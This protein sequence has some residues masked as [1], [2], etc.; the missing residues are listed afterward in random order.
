M[1]N[2]GNNVQ[3]KQPY[4][5]IFFDKSKCFH[6][7][8]L[9]FLR[10][11]SVLENGL[12]SKNAAMGI[13]VEISKNHSIGYNSTGSISVVESPSVNGTFASDCFEQYIRHGISFVI[14]NEQPYKAEEGSEKD[15]KF[16]DEAFI[17][18]RVE[19]ENIVGVMVPE[20]LL[21]QPLDMIEPEFFASNESG[22][23]P[24]SNLAE[25]CWQAINKINLETGYNPD[26]EKLKDL[27]Q[28]D[29]ELEERNQEIVN[30]MDELIGKEENFERAEAD[31]YKNNSQRVEL[32]KEL[33]KEMGAIINDAFK[34]KLGTENPTLRDVLRVYIPKYIKIYNSEGFEINL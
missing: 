25:R 2:L 13:G 16:K 31:F 12:L 19:K 7:V 9:D 30:G 27:L 32:G 22:S 4:G 18:G 21:D 3:E 33:Q 6:G 17:D 1:E 5:E 34:I 15:S 11:I 24:Y 14:A 26:T 20:S 28:K 10:M 8:G 29:K 23:A